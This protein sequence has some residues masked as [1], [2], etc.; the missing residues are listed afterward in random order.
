MFINRKANTKRNMIWGILRQMLDIVLRLLIR[1]I[2]IRVL[3][4]EYLGLNNLFSSILQV[5]SLAEAGF[6]SA[7]VF[8]MYKPIAEDDTEKICALLAY[9][10]RVYRI[11]GSFITIAGLCVMPFLG[12]LIEGGYPSDINIYLLYGIFLFDTASSYFLFSYKECL[13]TAHQRNDVYSRIVCFVM[14]A[15]Y[16]IQIYILLIYKNYYLYILFRPIATITTS[17]L[18]E[19]ITKRMYPDYRC[20]GT[21]GRQDRL[22]IREKIS[23]LVVAKLTDITRNSF[24]SIFVS[25]Y[26]GL[27][28]VAV[29]GNYYYIYYALL[30]LL[31]ILLSSIA[32]GVGNSLVVESKEKNFQDFKKISFLHHWLFS[33]CTVCL[34]CLYQPFMEIWVGRELVA[35]FPTMAIFC[36]Y[37]YVSSLGGVQSTYTGGRGL[38]W[39]SRKL[40]LTEAAVNIVLNWILVQALGIFGIILASIISSLLIWNVGSLYILFKHYFTEESLWAEWLHRI[41]NMCIVAV[42]CAITYGICRYGTFEN[43]WLTLI[44]RAL[45]CITVPNVLFWLVYRKSRAYPAAMRLL[46]ATLGLPQHQQNG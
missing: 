45:I 34:L 16:L 26:L 8:S 10:R 3:G 25:A 6:S 31:G 22:M 24:D 33:W 9:Y 14:L 13:L 21:L 37:F 32:A 43:L 28:A 41:G 18:C 39:E 27:T 30:L 20:A 42:V 19:I 12:Y 29:Y 1:T 15:E 46:F 44:V 4:A 11:I 38:W 7:I 2:V 35:P 17:I 23:G 40:Y 36:V 5:L